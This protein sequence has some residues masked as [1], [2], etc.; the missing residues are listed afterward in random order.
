MTGRK[1]G[2]LTVI[3]QVEDY[4]SPSGK[5]YDRWHCICDC[6]NDNVYVIGKSLRSKVTKACGCLNRTFTD[7]SGLKFGKLTVLERT[8]DYIDKSGVHYLMWKCICDCNKD[9]IV[10]VRGNNLKN[11][12]TQS[13]GCLQK[14]LA[15][16]QFKKYNTY[17]L[18]GEYGIGYSEE[19]RIFY[20][21]LEDYDKI[22]DYY[23]NYYSEK[24]HHVIG[25]I[26]NDK[27]NY[28][29]ELHRFLLNI[30]RNSKIIV[31]HINTHHPEDNRKANLRI[32]TQS[33]N[34]MN[35]KLA[36]NNKSGVVGVCWDKNNNCWLAQIGF[37]GQKIKLGRFKNKEDAIKARKEAEEKYFGEHSYDNSQKQWK[38]NFCEK[39]NLS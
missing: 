21:D 37:N 20:F 19:G 18:S 31:D 28:S 12:I 5:H 2:R 17:D 35:R 27:E 6:G 34:N 30:E 7:L 26:K 1:F 13:C 9:K 3:E 23:W 15:S 4:I 11:G 38:E 8:E 14:E 24:D 39:Q 32:V 29:I 10:Y 22:K 25:K 36:I 16:K 33:E